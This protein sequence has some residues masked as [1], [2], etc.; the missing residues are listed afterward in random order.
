MIAVRAIACLFGICLGMSAACAQERG[1]APRP[2][3]A[4]PSSYGA[5]ATLRVRPDGA[6]GTHVDLDVLGALGGAWGEDAV[7]ALVAALRITGEPRML[8]DDLTTFLQNYKLG[9][10]LT[11]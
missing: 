1:A 6:Q 2:E 9:V 3:I 7:R 4:R 5:S 11:F 10:E 8:P